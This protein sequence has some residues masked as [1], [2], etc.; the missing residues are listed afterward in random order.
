MMASLITSGKII[1]FT[2]NNL[3][4]SP[5]LGSNSPKKKKDSEEAVE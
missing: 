5:I 3:C 2:S 4:K 1:C